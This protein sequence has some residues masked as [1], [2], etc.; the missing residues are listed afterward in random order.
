M[1]SAS[2]V[3]KKSV[4]DSF[5]ALTTPEGIANAVLALLIALG[6]GIVIYLLYKASFKGVIY[7][8]SFAVTLIGMC[9]ITTAILLAVSSNVILSLGCVGALSIVRYRT[10]IK[11]PMDLMFLFLTVGVGVAL[12]SGYIYLAVLLVLF[13]AVFLLIVSKIGVT[14]EVYV[15]IIHYTGKDISRDVKQILGKNKH[16]IQS[17]TFRKQ[18]NEMAV[19]VRTRTR[20]MNFIEEI[21]NHEQ[22]SDVTV[23]AYNG[24]YIG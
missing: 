5:T 6:L 7:S 11:S 24:E 19:E 17:Q 10:A 8:E 1:N 21:R 14:E 15:L 3:I 13:T 16:K 2:D 9:V 18:D 4:L 22:V 12:G 20:D 23:V